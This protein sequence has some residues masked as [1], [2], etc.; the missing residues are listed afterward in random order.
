MKKSLYAAAIAGFALL[1]L[2]PAAASCGAA[3][4][5]VSTDWQAQG[6][7]HGAGARLDLRYEFVDQD[8]VMS[9][10][11]Q[12]SFGQ[13]SRHDDEVS[14]LNRN[15]LIG[16]S[17][18]TQAGW[19][20][21][22]QLP[23]VSRSHYHIHNHHGTKIPQR[24]QVEGLGDARISFNLPL[25]EQHNLNLLLGLKLPTGSSTVTNN[26]NELAERTLQP[27]TGSTD[28]LLGFT[29]NSVPNAGS[30]RWFAQAMWQHATAVRNSYRPGDQLGVDLGWRY[31]F[32]ADFSATVQANWQIRARDEGRN[33]EPIDSG[34]S[35]INLSPGLV[36]AVTPDTQL[37][38]FVQLPV[39]AH[40]NGVQLTAGKN[41]ALGLSRRF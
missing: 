27:G 34:R 2:N 14:T 15:L 24:W 12:V 20:V 9:G 18:N 17:Y 6:V 7:W 40:V 41:I 5:S 37:Y 39:H 11:D 8:Q 32:N 22:V 19:G 31:L 35:V 1:H 30:H 25:N 10:S 33:A 29:F 28:T 23:W 26:A 3:F 16:Y 21:N 38:A 13:I 36:Y 4:C